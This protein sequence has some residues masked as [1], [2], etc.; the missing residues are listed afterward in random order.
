MGTELHDLRVL[1]ST[2]EAIEPSFGD[3]YESAERLTPYAT[4]YR[5]PGEALIPDSEEFN[6]AYQAAK[7]ILT[8]VINDLERK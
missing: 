1:V 7:T 3:L 5:Y 6:Q 8:F 2:A 4:V